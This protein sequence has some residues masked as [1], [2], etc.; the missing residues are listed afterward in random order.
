[1]LTELWL[2]QSME[3]GPVARP[4]GGAK[5]DMPDRLAGPP[6]WLIIVCLSVLLWGAVG[7]GLG[8]LFGWL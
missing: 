6:A 8:W 4:L 3:R 7:L 2:T 1:M 5:A